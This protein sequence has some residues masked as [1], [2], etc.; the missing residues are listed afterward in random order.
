MAKICYTP[1]RLEPKTLKII[2]KANEILEN[3][4]AKEETRKQL[5]SK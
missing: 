3:F 5:W 4:A 2:E 1:L